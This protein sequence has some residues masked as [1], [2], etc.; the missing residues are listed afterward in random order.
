M[1]LKKFMGLPQDKI[2][3]LST[4]LR[5]D[6]DY[7]RESRNRTFGPGAGAYL[8]TNE[9]YCDLKSAF[10][11][12][13]EGK[14]GLIVNASGDPIPVFSY[15]GGG[16]IAGFDTSH[17]AIHWSELK[18]KAIE[19]LTFSQFRNFTGLSGKSDSSS[20]KHYELIREELSEYT[21]GMFDELMKRHGSLRKI[22][23]ESDDGSGLFRG[24]YAASCARINL[25]TQSEEIFE[26]AKKSMQQHDFRLIPG[27]LEKVAELISPNQFGFF[28]GSNIMDHFG[29]DNPQDYKLFL[30]NV[31]T[32]MA[33]DSVLIFNFEWSRSVKRWAT[34][35]MSEMGYN[36]QHLPEDIGSSG[37][38]RLCV[39]TRKK[40]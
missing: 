6:A 35:F 29:S 12:D 18:A 31:D 16:D 20:K 11:L 13:L 26:G 38:G 39:A 24:G 19:C 4:E 32:M 7:P 8:W 14:S 15:L 22:I 17:R 23:C 28:Y 36:V 3:D 9:G 1:K 33:E 10:D 25:F 40:K 34:E 2:H 37:C 27:T 30:Q 5:I 21:Q